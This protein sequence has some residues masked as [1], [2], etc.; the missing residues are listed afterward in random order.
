M[1]PLKPEEDIDAKNLIKHHV[2][3]DRVLYDVI[4]KEL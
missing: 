4:T 1:L 3:K 2:D